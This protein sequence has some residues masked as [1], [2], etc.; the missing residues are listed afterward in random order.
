MWSAV[1]V[2]TWVSRR[3]SRLDEVHGPVQEIIGK[4][5][6]GG[7]ATLIELSEKFDKVHLDSIVVD[8]DAREAAYE[9]VDARVTECLVEAEVRISR[10]HELQLPRGLW[11][12]EIE[13]GITLGVKTTPLSRVGAYVPGGRAAY[14]ST[15]LMCTIPARIAGVP[16]ICCCSP[17]PIQPLTLVALDIVGV[18]E[19]YQCG[20]A[21]AI[22]AMALGTETIEPVEKIVGPGNVYVTA[23]KMLLREYAEIDFPAGPSEIAVIADE[24]AVP[25]Y[26]A[27]DI[28]AQAEHD[29]Y[30]AC[31]L[32]TTSA[33]LANRVGAEIKKQAEHAPRREIISQALKNSGYIVA[34]D[35]DEAV[36]ISNV[37]APEHLS[38]Q[39]A[40]PLPVLGGIRNAGAIFV[41]P[42][43]PVA[44]GDYASGT[45]HVLPTAGYA[46]Q[47]SGL[48]VHHFCKTSSVQYLTK[49]GLE[50]I[51]EIIETLA[52]AE[53]LAAHAQ[54]VSMRLRGPHS[55]RKKNPGC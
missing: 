52:A 54:S 42:Y 32:I 2:E 51:G 34:G 8:D 17:P 26:V 31:I 15:A 48:D 6:T 44:C 50:S 55:H 47:Y 41:G 37:V 43:T 38:I 1:D 19:I 23:A 35:L 30:A 4:V 10:F 5:R 21:Q 28:L 27:A 45:N 29:P 25:A 20:G 22:A 53:G 16:E 39:V 3:T 46:R 36:A 18:K 11:L 49:D 9:Q 12:S 40:D 7:D 13:P 33:G 14:P 24:S